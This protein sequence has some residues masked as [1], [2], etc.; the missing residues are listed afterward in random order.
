MLFCTVVMLVEEELVFTN[1]APLVNLQ[2]HLELGLQMT[3]SI[4]LSKYHTTQIWWPS[5][6]NT[7]TLL[8][9]SVN[10]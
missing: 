7:D 9:L 1:F 2:E 10:T 8:K 3:N 4:K 6:G 5:G